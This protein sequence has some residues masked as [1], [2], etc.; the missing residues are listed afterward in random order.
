MGDRIWKDAVEGG[1][2]VRCHEKKVF[3][4]IKDFAHLSAAEFR[5][6][7]KITGEQIHDAAESMR[8]QT[9]TESQFSSRRLSFAR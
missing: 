7:W 6:S 3:A 5:N 4:K 8:G 2:P 9:P 1:D